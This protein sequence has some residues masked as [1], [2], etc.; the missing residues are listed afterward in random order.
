MSEN[1]HSETEFK[2]ENTVRRRAWIAKAL[3]SVRGRLDCVSDDMLVTEKAAK[4]DLYIIKT[5]D[6]G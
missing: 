1:K 5:D 2:N 6:P 3:D 4:P